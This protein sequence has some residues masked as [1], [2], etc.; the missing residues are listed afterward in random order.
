MSWTRRQLVVPAQQLAP[1][2]FLQSCCPM[3]LIDFCMDC[4][5]GVDTFTDDA[6]MWSVS[7]MACFIAR[8][9]ITQHDPMRLNYCLLSPRAGSSNASGRKSGPR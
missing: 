7:A 6:L 3:R 1:G 5:A 2:W 8:L 9:F 4:G